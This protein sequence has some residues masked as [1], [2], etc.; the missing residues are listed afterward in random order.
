M[1]SVASGRLVEL[2][3]IAR[4]ERLLATRNA[5]EVARLVGLDVEAVGEIKRGIHP[6][7]QVL[8]SLIRC[9]GCGGL[10]EPPCRL[11]ATRVIIGASVR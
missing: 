7:Q 8:R 2:G 4:V 11:C 1:G 5:H 9:S 10:V 3:I 6:R